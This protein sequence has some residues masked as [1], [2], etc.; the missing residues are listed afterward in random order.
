MRA[1]ASNG[2]NLSRVCT[3][4]GRHNRGP[5]VA[6]CTAQTRVPQSR[7]RPSTLG[8]TKPGF[9][10]DTNF[11]SRGHTLPCEPSRV[12]VVKIEAASAGLKAEWLTVGKQLGEGSF[13]VVYEGTMTKGKNTQEVVLKKAK[14]KVQGAEEMADIERLINERVVRRASGSCAKYLGSSRVSSEDS[15]NNTKLTEGL[16]LIWSLEGKMTLA[17]YMRYPSFPKELVEPLLGPDLRGNTTVVK[18]NTPALELIIAQ[19]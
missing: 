4:S 12:S 3:D 1:L 13:G 7:S 19:K 16:W 6:R 2:A 5:E 17:H 14:A 15:Q 10:G 18:N 11:L 8:N 9:L